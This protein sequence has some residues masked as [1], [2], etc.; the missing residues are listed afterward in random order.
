MMP[1]RCYRMMLLMGLHNTY[2]GTVT[3]ASMEESLRRVA[4]SML[5]CKRCH[6]NGRIFGVTD[7]VVIAYVPSGTHKLNTYS[8]EFSTNNFVKNNYDFNNETVMEIR[9]EKLMR[10][11]FGQAETLLYYGRKYHET[12]QVH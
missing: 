2:E 5:D 12:H 4:R 6:F 7:T 11:L 8:R 9:I 1:L 10:V 3:E